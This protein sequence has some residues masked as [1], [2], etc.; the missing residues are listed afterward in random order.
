MCKLKTFSVLKY[1]KE[2]SRGNSFKDEMFLQSI[3]S[4]SWFIKYTG[5]LHFLCWSQYKSRRAE[6]LEFQ[7][8]TETDVFFNVS[9]SVI[10]VGSNGYTVL[11]LSSSQ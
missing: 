7:I 8:K 9:F 6:D 11:C 3:L 2:S 10:S 1:G 5:K 4:E